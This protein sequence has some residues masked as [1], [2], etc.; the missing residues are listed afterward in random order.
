VHVRVQ[1]NVVVALVYV[2]QQSQLAG[3]VVPT[4]AVATVGATLTVFVLDY[5]V[6]E[7][8]HLLTYGASR[9]DPSLPSPPYTH[10]NNTPPPPPPVTVGGSSCPWCFPLAPAPPP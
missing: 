8:I 6:H 9:H 10:T 7:H 2:W 3:V 1:V 5:L 4:V